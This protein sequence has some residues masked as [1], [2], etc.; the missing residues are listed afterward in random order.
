M[1]AG[2]TG[3][4]GLGEPTPPWR[5]NRPVPSEDG[6]WEECGVQGVGALRGDRSPCE[7]RARAADP[8][9]FLPVLPGAAALYFLSN[10]SPGLS[11]ALSLDLR[12]RPVP[13]QPG[14]VGVT[15]LHPGAQGP[16]WD[17]SRTSTPPASG[18]STSGTDR[19]S[20]GGATGCSRWPGALERLWKKYLWA[21]ENGD[22]RTGSWFLVHS[23]LPVTLLLAVY[24]FLVVAGPRL[25]SGQEPPSLAGPLTAYNLGLVALS[26]YM[27]YEFMATLL[28]ANYSYLCQ[29]V[30]YSR[31]KLG[32]RM[33]RVCWWRFSKAV[34][35]LDTVNACPLKRVTSGSQVWGGFEGTVFFILRK[36]PEQITFLHVYHHGTMLFSWWAGV[37]YVLGGSSLL[38]WTAEL[39]GPHLHVPVLWTGQ[40]GAPPVASVWWKRHLT[41]LQLGQFVAI[42]AHSSYN[43]FAECPFPDGFNVAVLLYSLSLLTLF[44]NFYQQT[45]LRSKRKKPT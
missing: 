14:W 35:Y 37:K 4:A 41:V 15:A 20:P 11:A 28:L 26:G 13:G 22:P 44:F 16:V 33:A 9:D 5:R 17:P 43:L 45:Y 23:P 32:M 1:D 42:A 6:K 8:S 12:Q 38:R 2:G 18:Q 31:S 25:M 30:D 36:K 39:S 10:P 29:P 3:G 19:R 40:A 27:F 24:L 34:E 7:R 21:L